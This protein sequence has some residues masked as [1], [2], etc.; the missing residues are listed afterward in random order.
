[1]QTETTRIKKKQ[2]RKKKSEIWKQKVTGRK[3]TKSMFFR[4]PNSKFKLAAAAAGTGKRNDDTKRMLTKWRAS[5][6]KSLQQL[7]KF[8]SMALVET[9]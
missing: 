9:N 5:A 2:Q 8:S 3:K 7:I 4:L 1:M 6:R